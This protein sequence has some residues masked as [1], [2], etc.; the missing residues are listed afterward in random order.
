MIAVQCGVGCVV[1]EKRPQASMMIESLPL[2]DT[3][4]GTGRWEVV[5]RGRQGGVGT[6]AAVLGGSSLGGQVF[7]IKDRLFPFAF[8]LETSW[9]S[10]KGLDNFVEASG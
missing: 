9:A 10:C 5:L 4:G 8:R 1:I 2:L 7:V 3:S 6:R